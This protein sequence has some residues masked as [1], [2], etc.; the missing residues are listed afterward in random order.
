[1]KP[2][3]FDPKEKNDKSETPRTVGK[4]KFE[5]CETQKL[6]KNESSRPIKNAFEIEIEPKFFE[7]HVLQGTILYRYLS[8]AFRLL[9]RSCCKRMQPIQVYKEE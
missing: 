5:T 4:K 3:K 2:E 8:I 6:P 1:M 9:L 7:T